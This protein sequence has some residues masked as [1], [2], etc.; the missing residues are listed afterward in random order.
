[1]NRVFEP[2]LDFMGWTTKEDWDD[3]WGYQCPVGRG[4]HDELAADGDPAAAEWTHK[5]VFCSESEG[6][7]TIQ[8]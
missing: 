1:M 7:V 6:V 4:H 8:A 3:E 2:F 5:G